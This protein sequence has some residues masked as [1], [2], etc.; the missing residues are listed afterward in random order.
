MCIV[1]FA[2]GAPESVLRAIA[3]ILLAKLYRK[4]INSVQTNRYRRFASSEAVIRQTELI[5]QSRGRKKIS[6]PRA[7]TTTWT[8]SSRA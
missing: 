7:S 1:R 6:A 8:R 4:P 3:H 2:G 5:R